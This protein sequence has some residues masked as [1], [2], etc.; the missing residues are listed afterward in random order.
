MAEEPHVTRAAERLYVPR[1]ALSKQVRAPARRLGTELVRCGPRGVTLTEPGAAL[2]PPARQVLAEWVS[3]TAAP[4]AV[5]A[6][7]QGTRT[8][9]KGTSPGRGGLPPAIRSRCT[10]AHPDAVVR[11]R[12]MSRNCAFASSVTSRPAARYTLKRNS[13]TSPSCI[14]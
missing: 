10:A 9:G 2:L 4:D 7:R 6:A 11:L 5:P 14:T 3:G 8:V 12:R 1:P 13:T